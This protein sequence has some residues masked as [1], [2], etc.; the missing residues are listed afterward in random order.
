MEAKAF[1]AFGYVLLRT[2][3][4]AGE[5]INDEMMSRNVFSVDDPTPDETGSF[6]GSRGAYI[7]I[8]LSGVHTYTNLQTGAIDRH[9]RGWCNLVRPI[10]VGKH[11]LSVLEDSEYICFSPLV[12]SERSPTIPPMDLFDLADG[13]SK[14]LPQ[15]TKLYLIDGQLSVDEKVIPSMRQI[16]IASQDKEVT[17]IG[18]CLG[19][20]FKI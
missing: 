12:N 11:E 4:K 20:I 10:E 16:R 3:L 18:R 9:E 14:T 5:L 13:E 17:A 8:M 6:S 1:A 7:W 19:Y 2:K 15:G